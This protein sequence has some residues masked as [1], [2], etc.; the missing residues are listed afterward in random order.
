MKFVA[1]DLETIPDLN[2]ARDLSGESLNDNYALDWIRQNRNSAK[3]D[4]PV[5]PRLH[6]HKIISC[7]VAIYDSKESEFDLGCLGYNDTTEGMPDE[8]D[9]L[10]DFHA[11][12]DDEPSTVLVSWNGVNFDLPVV[13]QR[14]FL[15][16]VSMK[17][18]C[19]QGA[20][21]DSR[22][23]NN[24]LNRYHSLHIDLCDKLANFGSAKPKLGDMAVACGLGG[25]LGVG[26]P[27]VFEA[28]Q[29]GLYDEIDNYCEVD[30]LLTALLYLRYLKLTGTLIDRKFYDA[31]YDIKNFFEKTQNDLIRQFAESFDLEKW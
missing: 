26:G 18:L 6:M 13:L 8:K 25:K 14:S 4:D 11:I 29:Q 22:K 10:L 27:N 5:F 3:P 16:G 21:T 7:A 19:D 9:I 24:Y 17:S 15:Q 30:S 20:L 12:L 2:L 23:Y 31:M 1:F 28:Y